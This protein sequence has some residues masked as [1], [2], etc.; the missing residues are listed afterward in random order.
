MGVGGCRA[1]VRLSVG[2]EWHSISVEA[3]VVAGLCCLWCLWWW[4]GVKSYCVFKLKVTDGVYVLRI[5]RALEVDL[6]FSLSV[7]GKCEG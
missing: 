1:G 3:R 6:A 5:R 2:I 7:E 4:C